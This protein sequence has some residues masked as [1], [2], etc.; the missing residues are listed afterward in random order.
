N[1]KTAAKA[2][3]DAE[4]AKDPLTDK[5]ALTNG[6]NSIDEATTKAAVEAAKNAAIT[7]IQ[8]AQAT[9]HKDPKDPD[10]GDASN[11]TLWMILALFASAG[12]YACL[13]FGGRRKAR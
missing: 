7:A 3:L 4:E 10:A 13:E 9:E 8:E 11:M 5:T 6:K 12:I 2:A 1:A